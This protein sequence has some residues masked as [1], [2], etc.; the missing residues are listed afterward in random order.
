M[1]REGIFFS[2]EPDTNKQIAAARQ[3]RNG[4]VLTATVDSTVDSGAVPAVAIGKENGDVL[5]YGPD[6]FLKTIPK[7]TIR[8]AEEKTTYRFNIKSPFKAVDVT[9][10]DFDAMGIVSESRESES[11]FFVLNKNGTFLHS[12]I[13]EE[14]D[15]VKILESSREHE[16]VD[17]DDVDD[18]YIPLVV[19]N[20][21][22]EY[23]F[24][25]N[26]R[27]ARKLLAWQIK[28]SKFTTKDVVLETMG[29]EADSGVIRRLA[30]S[31]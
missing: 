13:L 24:S 18:R 10:D 4:E 3:D 8:A 19:S 23:F 22:T 25:T 6:D 20:N 28:D 21:Q 14:N 29:S 2:W 16:L 11:Y 12:E 26:P 5:Y 30:I 7:S 1:I 9:F 27:D 17:S 15:A 31:P